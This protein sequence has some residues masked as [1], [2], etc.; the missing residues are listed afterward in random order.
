MKGDRNRKKRWFKTG[1]PY[2]PLK[3]Q[4]AEMPPSSAWQPRLTSEMYKLVVRQRPDGTLYIPDADGRDG[5]A[6]ILHPR[7]PTP[8]ICEQYLQ[9]KNNKASDDEMRLLHG[10]KTM[11]MYNTV[12]Q[13]HPETCTN[14][15]IVADT[16]EKRGV[17]WRQQLRCANCNY[18]SQKFNLYKET[19]TGKR[20]PGTAQPNLGLQVALQDTTM[21]SA[22]AR[23]LF[24]ATNTPLAPLRPK[25]DAWPQRWLACSA[26]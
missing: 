2:F 10:Q 18:R 12:I 15:Q 7:A 3:K 6:R 24:A 19:K 5:P 9:G 21:G 14:L 13:Q 20:G 8:S 22:K 16:E 17:C 23:L 1:H 25:E 26:A 11:D 4:E